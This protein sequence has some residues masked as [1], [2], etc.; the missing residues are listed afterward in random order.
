MLVLSGL[1]Q[2]SPDRTSRLHLVPSRRVALV[3]SWPGASGSRLIASG[4]SGQVARVKVRPASARP[5]S[6]ELD[7]LVWSRQVLSSPVVPVVSGHVI[8]S[9]RVSRW[10]GPGRSRRVSSCRVE[11]RQIQSSLVT[12]VEARLVDHVSSGPFR[13]RPGQSG[14]AA[15]R[16]VASGLVLSRQVSSRWSSHV[17][18]RQVVAGL[19]L[20]GHALSRN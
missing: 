20:S 19:V 4:W 6:A 11:A 18:P 14:L 8:A 9:P 15:S 5:D 10:S 2:A 1:V 3:R 13:A 7:S 16:P 12:L 17:G